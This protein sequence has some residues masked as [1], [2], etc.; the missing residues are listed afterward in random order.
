MMKENEQE[1]VEQNIYINNVNEFKTKNKELL[2]IVNVFCN[3]F[4]K[5]LVRINHKKQ[6]HRALSDV[7]ALILTANEIERETLFAYFTSRRDTSTIVRGRIIEKYPYN[8]MVY[9][10]FY[11]NDIK[12]VH[13]E[14]EMTGS[15]SWGGTAETLEKAIKVVKPSVVI[16]LGVAFGN[17]IKKQK[18]GDV[19]V[20]RQFF[21]YD[22]SVKMKGHK[23]DIKKLH[24]YESDEN[25]RYKMKSCMMFESKTKGLF[26][27]EFQAHIGNILTG[28]YV[29]DSED[30]RDVIFKPF[31]AFGIIGGEMEAFGMFSVLKKNNERRKW[32]QVH[33]I[34]IKG[35]C[36]WAAGKNSPSLSD[37][38]N[39]KKAEEE[40]NDLQVLAMCNACSVCEKLL[41]QKKFFS[42]YRTRGMKKRFWR[43]VKNIKNLFVKK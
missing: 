43:Y 5:T 33:G 13:V 3:S 15:Y 34:M 31:K 25:L 1:N 19:L 27:N 17:D 35:I 6:L 39:T 36:D 18:M 37:P 41:C 7:F 24:V 42:D 28:E 21:A 32:S 10:C 14:P 4:D 20:G 2:Q 30:F 29:I 23:L 9:S 11:I 38:E 26:G 12:V 8:G 22:K 40:K 16:S